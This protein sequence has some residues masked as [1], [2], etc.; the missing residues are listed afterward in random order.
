MLIV[1]TFTVGVHIYNNHQEEKEVFVSG[2]QPDPCL[3][4]FVIFADPKV[5]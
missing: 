3:F 5:N 1:V 2:L 4:L